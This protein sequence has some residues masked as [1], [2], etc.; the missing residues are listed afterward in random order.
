MHHLTCTSL[1]LDN[2]NSSNNPDNSIG[3]AIV[4]VPSGA[5]IDW[6]AD[7]DVD[8]RANRSKQPE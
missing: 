6:L 1:D 8:S 7:P 5:I 2:P 4:D 3:F